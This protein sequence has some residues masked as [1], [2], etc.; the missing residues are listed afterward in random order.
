MLGQA[1]DLLRKDVLEWVLLDEIEVAAQGN[2]G[3]EA[4]FSEVYILK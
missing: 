4:F 3:D 1:V 2:C